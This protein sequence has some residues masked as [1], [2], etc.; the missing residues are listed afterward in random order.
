M[1]SMIITSLCMFLTMQLITFAGLFYVFRPKNRK[2]LLYVIVYILFLHS[3]YFFL[4]SP[5]SSSLFV[6]L[7]VEYLILYPYFIYM[8]IC[9]VMTPFFILAGVLLVLARFFLWVGSRA[10][11][12]KQADE[13]LG[14]DAG[15]RIF[16]KVLTSSVVLPL[17]GCSVYG[18]YVE[19]D[20]VEVTE[21]ELFYKDLP[22]DLDGFTITQISDIH[23][24][25]F[26][27]GYRLKGFVDK[28][29][30]LESDL[31]VITG[32]IINW[33]STFIREAIDVLS[34]LKAKKG[35]FAVLGNHDFYGD[36]KDL[37]NNL[38]KSGVIVLRNKYEK[39]YN[40]DKRSCF[41]LAGIDDP[42][43]SWYLNE[44]FPFVKDTLKDVPKD[45][46]KVLL[47]HRPNVFNLASKQGVHLTLAG[48]T[49]GGQIILPSITGH[50]P[51]LASI[52]YE[53]DYGLY[54]KKDSFLYVNKGLG[55]VGPPVR[56]NCP[57]EITRIVLRT[58]KS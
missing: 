10:G 49:H 23:A 48:H 1:A 41:Y 2:L 55:V 36:L 13:G 57:R 33:G 11:E 5:V 56:V 4:F 52:A 18:A 38:E 58:G 12:H 16:M 19:R 43:G 30:A 24:G 53:H 8:L 25:P 3:S 46:F 31:V 7:A 47:S 50:A 40:E 6:R 29:N 21:E 35:V 32:D 37:C 34:G 15:R 42:R 22:K 14:V 44:D 39:I 26:M 54:Q 9:M 45:G 17:A 27:D 20:R 51:S 28:M